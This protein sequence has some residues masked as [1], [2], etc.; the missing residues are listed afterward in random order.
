V[1]TAFDSLGFSPD[2]DVDVD[3]PIPSD[4]HWGCPV[5]RFPSDD[6]AAPQVAID[7]A[8]QPER[9]FVVRFRR[10]DGTEWVGYFAQRGAGRMCVY[11]C[12]NPGWALVIADEYA[13]LVDVGEPERPPEPSFNRMFYRRI[14][15]ARVPGRDLVLVWDWIRAVAIGSN[16]IVWDAM[17]LSMN[18]QGVDLLGLS[19]EDVSF[20]VVLRDHE[21]RVV[22]SIDSGETLSVEPLTGPTRLRDSFTALES[23]RAPSIRSVDLDLPGSLID[24]DVTPAGGWVAITG[25]RDGKLV[26]IGGRSLPL[27]RPYRSPHIRTIDEGTV[28]VYSPHGRPN[29]PNAIVLRSTGEIASEF[30]IGDAIQDVLAS[31]SA[32]VVLYFDEGIFGGV[33]PSWEGVAVFAPGGE[34][35]FGYR[36]HFGDDAVQV[37]DAQAGGWTDRGTA[38]FMPYMDFQL[39]ELDLERRTQELAPT[40]EVLHGANALTSAGDEIFVHGPYRSESTIWRWT[41][42][43][44]PEPIGDFGPVLRGLRGGRFLAFRD[45]EYV[46]ISVA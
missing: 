1:V 31:P 11:A 41:P 9:S 14:A 32:L 13:Y 24:L 36:E 21:E 12:P 45:R 26:Y 39:V 35:R 46:V 19:H 18:E 8:R 6:G 43:E 25:S 27:P 16:G 30:A 7:A 34:L 5:H 17:L 22:I 15:A 37:D 2:W 38:L 4:G 3:P 40:P 33:W 10:A 28:L 42:G 20:R 44:E 23:G 29:E